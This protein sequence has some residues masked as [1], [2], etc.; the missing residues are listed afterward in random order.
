M[1]RLRGRRLPLEQGRVAA[2]TRERLKENAELLLAV[3]AFAA[4]SGASRTEDVR[5]TARVTNR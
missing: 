2:A 1:R 5:V 3:I 4:T